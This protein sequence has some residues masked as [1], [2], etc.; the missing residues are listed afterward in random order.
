VVDRAVAAAAGDDGKAGRAVDGVVD[1][2]GAVARADQLHHVKIRPQL[3]QRLVRQLGVDAEVGQEHRGPVAA[4]AD[5]P[6][7]QR[8]AFGAAHVQLQRALGAI[9]AGPVQ[10]APGG[11]AR[12]AGNVDVAADRVD[13][14]HLGAELGQCQPGAGRGDEGRE[15]DDAQAVQR[16]Q[17]RHGA[18]AT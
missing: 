5:Q 3:G 4:G 7:Q 18:G 14:D 6:L 9:Q 2:V 17:R 12:R 8:A 1:R 13:A 11:V 10:A 16:L 15:L